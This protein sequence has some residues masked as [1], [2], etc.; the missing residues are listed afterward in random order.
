MNY[1][2]SRAIFWFVWWLACDLVQLG[3]DDAGELGDADVLRVRNVQDFPVPLLTPVK[4][5]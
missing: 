3:R 4:R 1:F 5:R 2:S